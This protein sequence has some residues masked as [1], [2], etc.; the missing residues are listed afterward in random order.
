MDRIKTFEYVRKSSPLSLLVL[1]ACGGASTN[2]ISVT[3]GAVTEEDA[4][5]L[6]ASGTLTISDVDTDEAVFVAQTDTDGGA[7]LGVFNLGTD[8]AW[9]YAADNTNATIQALGT[10]DT[11]T[12]T[13]TAVSADGTTQVVTVTITGVND[14]PT[15]ANAISDQTIAE[16]SALSFQ[17]APDVFADVDAGDSLTYTAT[18]ADDSD[19]PSWLSFDADTRTFSGT[20]LNANVGVVAVKVTA[21]DGSSAAVS[22]TFNITVTA[23]GDSSVSTTS[24]ANPSVSVSGNVVKGPLNNALVGLDYDGDGIVDSATVRTSSDGSFSISTTNTTYTVIAVTDDTTI[25][26]SSGIILSGVTLKAPKGAGVITPTTTLMEEGSLTADQVAT[27]LGLPSGVDPLTFN[28]F[29]AGVDAATALAVEKSS[30]KIMSVVKAFSSAAEG[31]GANEAD[32]FASALNS[33][34]EVVKAKAEKLTD[35]NASAADKSL[36]LSNTADLALIKNQ[37]KIEMLTTTGVDATAF[38]AVAD[39]TTSAITNVNAKIEAVLDLTSDATKNAFSTTQVLAN[40]VKTA[41]TAEVSSA[42]SGNITFVDASVVNTAASNAAPTNIT[43]NSSSISE[44]SASLV[45]G[46]LSTVDS[47]QALGMAFTYAIAEVAET[48]YSAFSIDQTTGELSL[49]AQPD[50]ETKTSYTVTI[51]S[52]DDGGKTF[53]KSFS[54]TVANTN[55]APTVAN[56]ISD[57][58]IAEDSALSFQFAPDVF[59]DVDAGDSLTYTATLA[60]DSDLPSW[61]S[62][63]ADTRT[64]SGTPLNAN[65]GAIDVKV[66]ATDSG[67]AAV[68]DTFKVTVTNTN[69]VATIAGVT[70]GAVTEED[71]A[72]LTASGT[73]TISDVDT[74]EA[75]FVAQTDTA[76]GAGLGVFNLGTDGAWT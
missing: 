8:G 43:L 21:T 57:Q 50:Y 55:D 12:D 53:S 46:I 73:L 66:T 42:G 33:L 9:T 15:V 37:A 61:L 20:P 51:L 29:A 58:T 17:F 18:L 14:A 2:I 30:Q 25:D 45:I 41:A 65:V 49:K 34:V 23:R 74:D 16:D 22:D 11:T 6:T 39:D 36:D 69:D 24:P 71:A 3:T 68:T 28:P 59:A 67:S 38:D 35:T 52:T 27:V 40:Q 5:S 26:T 1:A 31:A 7:G 56:A 62:F 13:F 47:D 63:D 4:N 32:A 19:L 64:F 10:G 48:D 72:S 54:V 60:D 44:D 76:G 70:T 75:V